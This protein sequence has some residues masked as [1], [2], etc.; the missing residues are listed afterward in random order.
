MYTNL[1]KEIN[2]MIPI[3]F[4]DNNVFISNIY[5]IGY[6]MMGTVRGVELKMVAVNLCRHPVKAVH[7]CIA[8]SKIVDKYLIL[9]AQAKNILCFI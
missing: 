5:C 8:I 2:Y 3:G 9:F 1:I 4:L 6:I 7:H